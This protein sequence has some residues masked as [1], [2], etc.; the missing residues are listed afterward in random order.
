[1][2]QGFGMT[3]RD[4]LYHH[5]QFSSVSGLVFRPYC[6]KASFFLYT[7]ILAYGYFRSGA[8]FILLLNSH[9]SF[10]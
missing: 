8:V 10:S 1:M 4:A 2:L 6:L 7:R 3:E 5:G 9:A